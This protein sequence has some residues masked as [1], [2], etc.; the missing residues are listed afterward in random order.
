M[1]EQIQERRLLSVLPESAALSLEDTKA[2]L[3]MFAAMLDAFPRARSQEAKTT[4]E[5][6]LDLTAD[7]PIGW[8]GM[9]LKFLMLHPET[10]FIPTIGK[11][12]ERAAIEII[13][14]NRLAHGKDPD[15]NDRGITTVAAHHIDHWIHQARQLMNLPEI[16][17]ASSQIY[18]PAELQDSIAQIEAGTE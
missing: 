15:R 10:T 16:A 17:P 13:R 3:S 1:T 18:I 8:L 5:A 9:A 12:R 14:S 11:L 7:I 6:Y 4:I 2:R